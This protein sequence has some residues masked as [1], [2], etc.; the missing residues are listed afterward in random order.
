MQPTQTGLYLLV[1]RHSSGPKADTSPL[2][3]GHHRTVQS[4]HQSGSACTEAR[5][6]ASLRH[7]TKCG[8]PDRVSNT[9]DEGIDIGIRVKFMCD[10]RC[11]ARQACADMGLP[12]VA[13][14]RLVKKVSIPDDID[15]KAILPVTVALDINTD[16][17]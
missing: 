1:F 2:R 8:P 4:A 9:V 17:L 5:Y 15:S 16:S 11:V 3:A 10:R 6:R 12:I 7:R 14:P 13:A